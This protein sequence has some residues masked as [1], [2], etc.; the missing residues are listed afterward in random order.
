MDSV[1][2]YI[3]L[4]SFILSAIFLALSIVLFFAFHIVNVWKEINGS[5]AMNM[6]SS[7][8]KRQMAEMRL[9][10]EALAKQS[11]VNIFDEMENWADNIDPASR[12]S[13]ERMTT[14]L[15]GSNVA[16][17]DP[18]THGAG[19]AGTTSFGQRQTGADFVIEK[20]IASVAI[21]KTL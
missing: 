5:M 14:A 8:A 21:K 10:N 16:A 18:S 12:E 13:I 4:T 9:K 6:N 15:F 2:D 11:G 17:A 3:T 1:Y 7:L 20:E 19:Y